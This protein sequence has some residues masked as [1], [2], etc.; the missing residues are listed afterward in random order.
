MKF[1]LEHMMYIVGGVLLVLARLLS[2]MLVSYATFGRGSGTEN[3]K[4]RRSA[5]WEMS[6]T[7]SGMS[8]FPFITEFV[9]VEY[10]GLAS[11]F[12]LPMKVY[13]FI[14]MPFLVRSFGES[15]SASSNSQ[16]GKV[17]PALVA[18]VKDPLTM[19]VI[20]GMAWAGFTDG[21]GTQPL[22]FVGKAIDT[23]AQAQTPCLFLLIGLK[24]T[25]ASRTP[26]FC[27]TLLLGTQGVLLLMA[28]LVVLILSPGDT[29]AQFIILFTQGAPKFNVV[30]FM[31]AAL[32]SGVVG[33]SPDFALDILGLAFPI[34]S[35][36]Q[37]FAGVMGTSYVSIVGI[38]GAV[39]VA[40]SV[41]LRVTFK[42]QF[43][44]DKDKDASPS[45][46]TQDEKVVGA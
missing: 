43:Q 44:E 22:G 2:S 16:G 27:V 32:N 23:M 28:W 34:S 39:L 11:V 25:F 18:L 13:T 14:M 33:Y 45:L 31:Q 21:A 7:A 37:C 3:A 35:F 29:M 6:S 1:E 10:V 17:L 26:L 15:S 12:D 36:M 4:L 42:S 30:G 19:S 40:I 20:V 9:G 24:L 38:V 5:I 8:I 46:G 41:G